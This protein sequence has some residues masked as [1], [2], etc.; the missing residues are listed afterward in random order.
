MVD[1]G[2]AAAA[3]ALMNT[4][5]NAT[6]AEAICAAGGIAPLVALL[7]AGADSVAAT[8]AVSAVMNLAANTIN[9]EA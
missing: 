5:F 8:Y 3:G 1:W 7:E 2:C 6:N 9:A 4:S